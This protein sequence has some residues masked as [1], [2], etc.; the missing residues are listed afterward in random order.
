MHDSEREIV[1]ETPDGR[2]PAVVCTPPT[3]G[4]A[5]AILLLMEA[6]GLTGHIR[7]VAARLAAEGYVVLDPR[8]FGACYTSGSTAGRGSCRVSRKTSASTASASRLLTQVTH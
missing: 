1:I 8:V 6:F 5:P 2:M 3:P 4:R 7:T